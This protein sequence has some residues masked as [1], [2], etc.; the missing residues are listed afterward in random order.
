MKQWYA[1]YVS[2]YSY[3]VTVMNWS[4]VRDSSLFLHR[5]PFVLNVMRDTGPI[6]KACVRRREN[7]QV[8]NGTRLTKT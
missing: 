8:G 6:G 1:L 4:F 3:D 5:W 7:P 2:L